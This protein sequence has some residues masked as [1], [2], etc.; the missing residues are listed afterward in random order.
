VAS[1]VR[2]VFGGANC[3]GDQG[4]ALHRN[5]DF[6]DYVVRGEGET[7]FP[8]LLTA[9]SRADTAALAS[10]PGLCWRGPDGVARANPMASRPL[11]PNEIISPDYDGYFERLE[12]SAARSWVEPK[13]VV[14]GARGCWWGEKHH[15]KFC[16]LN[17]SFMQF[18]SKSPNQ[19]YDEIIRLVERH[20][21]LDMYVVDN[22]LDMGYLTTLL[23]R[24]TESGYDLRLHYEIKGNLRRDQLTALADAGL[25][26]VQP[27]V[28]N[29]STRVLKIMDKGI[30]GC[31]NVRLLRDA[32]SAG[33][34]P[35][36]N[37]LYGFPGELP[38]DYLP[39]IEQFPALH[40]LTPL[41]VVARIV[42]ERFSPY[43]NRP[44]LGFTPLAPAPP[45]RRIYDL[46]EA[47]LMDLAYMFSAPELGIDES[48]A[49][50]LRAAAEEWQREHV[51]SRLSQL[52]LGDSIVLISRRR[53]FDW[54]VL[55]LRDPVEVAAFRLLDQPHKP[56]AL[57]R[58]LAGQA[59][60]AGI[61]TLLDR[62]RRLGIVFT[63]A[64]Q[65][66]HVA[67]EA[68]NDE[69]LRFEE[70]FVGSRPD[71]VGGADSPAMAEAVGA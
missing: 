17:G 28:E 58:K 71:I 63:D 46:P 42:V 67:A 50:Q 8:A 6:V 66:V 48:V 23:P 20:Q 10:T 45:Y 35:A 24:L 37:Y 70:H 57:L 26:S 1:D 18:R 4:A 11:L 30:T 40:H 25:V 59:T 7:A 38:E 27:G 47:E 41:D 21:V 32:A 60:A 29:L 9:L 44:E 15:C 64:G 14:E 69:L 51:R 61:E 49:D 31:Q 19:F 55:T 43:F 54:T 12:S 39:L 36:W 56:A 22:I 3:D 33:L 65:Y 5:F 52:D 62:W 13:L 16:G 53:R 2:T 34:A 68:T